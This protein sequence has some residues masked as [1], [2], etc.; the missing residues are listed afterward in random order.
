M[1]FDIEIALKVVRGVNPDDALQLTKAHG[2]HQW[3]L[4]ILLED[5]KK[6]REA[7]AYIAQLD[8]FEA[9]KAMLDFG[10]ILISNAPEETTAFL[11]T[12]CTDSKSSAIGVGVLDTTPGAHRARPQD[13]LHLF[14]NKSEYLVDFLEHLVQCQSGWSTQIYNALVEHY[15]VRN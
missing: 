10:D 11:K 15:L 5:Q 14:L 9:E 7:I 13:Y 2:K 6:Y 8:L 1:D 12:F 3:V 4:R